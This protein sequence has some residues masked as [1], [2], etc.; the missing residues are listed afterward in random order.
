MTNAACSTRNLHAR[1]ACAR[2]ALSGI[3]SRLKE[4][5]AAASACTPPIAERGTI[6]G[7]IVERR[8]DRVGVA[9]LTLY[10]FSNASGEYFNVSS[11]GRRLMAGYYD[12]AGPDC[13]IAGRRIVGSNRILDDVHVISWKRGN[14][15]E[16]LWQRPIAAGAGKRD[17]TL[18]IVSAG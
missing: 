18:R 13:V 5:R 15:E 11:E 16:R 2:D 9:D 10:F 1:P 8:M 7:Q 3:V 14:W 4:L 17:T 6:D 12:A